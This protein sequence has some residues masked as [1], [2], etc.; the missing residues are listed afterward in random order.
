MARTGGK[1]IAPSSRSRRDDEWEEEA[2]EAE[3]AQD[4][5]IEEPGSEQT[6]SDDNDLDWETGWEPESEK[7][8]RRTP[9]WLR[10]IRTVLILAVLVAV[11]A[12]AADMLQR[13]RFAS[14]TDINGVSVSRMTAQE[15]TAAVSNALQLDKVITL[16]D[17]KGDALAQLNVLD[18]LRSGDVSS[19]VEKVLNSQHE[20]FLPLAIVGQGGGSYSLAW[21]DEGS[22]EAMI[23]GAIGDYGRTEATP[24][25]LVNGPNGWEL[26]EAKDGTM[27]DLG[28]AAANLSAVLKGGSLSSN[29]RVA[30]PLTSVAGNFTENDAKLQAQMNAINAA[31]GKTVTINFGDD[32]KVSLG[33][34]EL[35]GAYSVKLTDTGAE[36]ELDK[37]ALSAVLDKFIE[38]NQADGIARKYRTLDRHG[39][40][41]HFND[42]DK[43]WVLNREALRKDVLAA[44]SDGGE[45]QAQYSYVAP[46]K[47]HFKIGNNSFIE[48]DLQNQHLWFYRKGNLVMHTSIVSGSI[49][50]NTPTPCGAFSVSYTKQNAKLTGPDYSYTVSYWIPFY[51]NI[52]IH[53]ASWRTSNYGDDTYLTAD[54]SHGCIEVPEEAAKLIYENASTYIPVLVY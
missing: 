46:V 51:G 45:V 24:A 47:N 28:L 30:V 49:A 26:T 4:E 42:W 13:D 8:R 32:L 20:A 14:M 2:F 9:G 19:E 37:D 23:A 31:M 53:D 15:A 5:W 40:D 54:G 34:A 10:A 6:P 36:V 1:H 41:V 35:A 27:P 16:T 44:I 43:G 3:A 11:A 22:L 7:R 50:N 17:E 25:S 12:F 48:I 39:A 29:A 33:K 21:L 38:D 52:G 18:M